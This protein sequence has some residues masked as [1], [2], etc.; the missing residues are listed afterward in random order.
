M[1]M[2]NEKYPSLRNK[3][4]S[5]FLLILYIYSNL[6]TRKYY[7]DKK[8]RYIKRTVLKNNN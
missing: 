5:F 3:L 2:V 7:K 1:H 8:K 4:K 6:A